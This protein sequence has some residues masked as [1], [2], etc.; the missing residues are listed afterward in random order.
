MYGL[1]PE[2]GIPSILKATPS[3]CN[4]EICCPLISVTGP[5]NSIMI[6]Q[7]PLIPVVGFAAAPR[8]SD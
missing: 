7:L 8:G 5:V 4:M 6:P 3:S 1:K 2:T